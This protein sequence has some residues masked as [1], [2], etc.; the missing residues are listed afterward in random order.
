MSNF[1]VTGGAGFIGS[2]FVDL[3]LSR[4]STER[5]I[6]LDSLTYAGNLKNLKVTDSRVTFIKGNILDDSIVNRLIPQVDYVVNF[7]A[8]SHVDNSIKDSH[9]FIETNVLGTHVLLT[10]SEKNNIKK[11]LQVST[12]E[13]YG[14]ISE[15]S[16]D[17][18][19]PLLPNSPYSASKASADLLVRAF[20][21]T[22]D[23]NTNI[24]RC[25]NNF[26]PR[27]Y[28]E[29]FIPVL[30]K[31]IQMQ[32]KLPV[33]GLGT[34]IRDWIHVEDHCAAIE[35][36]LFHGES[37]E[38]YNVGG[39]H[40]LNNINLAK[41]LLEIFDLS[42]DEILYVQDRKGHDFR[43]SVDWSKIRTT[44]GFKPKKDFTSN[45]ASTVDWYLKNPKWWS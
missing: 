38:T 2:H 31:K 20:H 22:F 26:G 6:V 41:T 24:T 40:E 39:G 23:L 19:S 25:S 42:S 3:L 16:W 13:V 35:L 29:K 32:Q 11:F 1:L 37:G 44:L 15:G 18:N 36:V 4:D 10:A 27:Q 5:I 8:E 33:Y 17:E 30:I 21:N 14:S 28:P 12:D 7:A 34:N 9:K 45:L 43:Y